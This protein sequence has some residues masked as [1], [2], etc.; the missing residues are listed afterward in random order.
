[1]T[2]G[3]EKEFVETA[4]E[5]EE[6]RLRQSVRKEFE[7]ETLALLRKVCEDKAPSK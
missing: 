5:R 4:K 6:D 1:V 7:A 2:D 3:T